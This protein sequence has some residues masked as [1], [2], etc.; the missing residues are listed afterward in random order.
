MLDDAEDGPGRA[1]AAEAPPAPIAMPAGEVDFACD[2]LPNPR[3]V[4]GVCYFT[5]EFVA[6]RARKA[7]VSALKFE[8]RRTDSGGQHANPGESLWHARQGM[9][10]KTH[11]AGFQVNG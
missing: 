1:M 7:V 10:A 5:D 3:F 11:T 6:G 2:T 9:M 8:I 4:G